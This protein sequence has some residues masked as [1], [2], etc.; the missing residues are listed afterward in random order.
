[1]KHS[2]TPRAVVGFGLLLSVVAWWVPAGETRGALQP[3]AGRLTID[4]L[5]DITHPSA[6]VWSRDSK[7]VAFLWD[8][9]GVTNLYVSNAD[10]ATPPRARTAGISRDDRDVEVTVAAPANG[11]RPGVGA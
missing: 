7:R 8:R 6:P 11:V 3:A 2:M 1:M 4:T 5:V 9:A 10:G